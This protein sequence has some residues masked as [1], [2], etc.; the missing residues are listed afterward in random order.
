M[1]EAMRPAEASRADLCAKRLGRGAS[2]RTETQTKSR[3]LSLG[4]EAQGLRERH[5]GLEADKGAGLAAQEKA[6]G[7]R[8]YQ[9]YRLTGWPRG[10]KG[11]EEEGRGARGKTKGRE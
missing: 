6:D 8:G 1:Q 11:S 2:Q 5:R 9:R 4:R 10:R 7:L 3:D